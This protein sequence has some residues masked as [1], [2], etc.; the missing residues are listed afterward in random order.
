MP[1]FPTP[2]LVTVAI[3]ALL[4]VFAPQVL[5]LGLLLVAMA[6]LLAIAAVV[7]IGLVDLA[8]P[9]RTDADGH[10]LGFRE[11]M[12]LRL[13]SVRNVAL[14]RPWRDPVAVRRAALRKV[15]RLR[16]ARPAGPAAAEHICVYAGPVTL[17]ALDAYQHLEEATWDLG[18]QY[19]QATQGGQAAGP[20]VTVWLFSDPELP[21]GYVRAR[22]LLREPSP[23]GLVAHATLELAPA[24]V[25]PRG[26]G[27]RPAAGYPAAPSP[28]GAAPQP[29]PQGVGPAA[30]PSPGP[31][32]ATA[33]LGRPAQTRQDSDTLP[34]GIAADPEQTSVI[35]APEPVS[36]PTVQLLDSAGAPLGAPVPLPDGARLSVG[37][38]PESDVVVPDVHVSRTHIQMRASGGQVWVRDLGSRG[39]TAVAGRRLQSGEEV[40][41]APGTVIQ[42]SPKA[43]TAGG[44]TPGCAAMMRI[45]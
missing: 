15:T 32:D 35:A 40:A 37:R 19:R 23:E 29:A 3:F 20:Q 4:W 30:G 13:V 6:F 28:V 41:V 7:V 39:G 11:R 8:G 10:V 9:T 17:D 22:A 43:T 38:A 34:G 1:K 42:L 31:G 24:G 21:R 16:V 45:G 27:A 33:V 44:Q 25:L 12:R 2:L 36:R 26:A 18:E 5:Q 14:A